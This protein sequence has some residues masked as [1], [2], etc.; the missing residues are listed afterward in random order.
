MI[1]ISRLLLG[2][3][4]IAS[5]V[6]SVS[7]LVILW[8]QVRSGDTFRSSKSVRLSAAI[9]IHGAGAI[10][11]LIA[12]WIAGDRT[13]FDPSVY[14]IWATWTIW[15]VA[16]TLVIEVSGKLQLAMCLYSLWVLI[17]VAWRLNIG[18]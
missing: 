16:K 13:T 4:A 1:D 17:W 15:L 8:A 14:L 12:T 2:L 3:L 18:G 5:M 6:M 9:A 11:L 10:P 7:S